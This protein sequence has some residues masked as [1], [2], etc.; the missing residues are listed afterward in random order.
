MGSFGGPALARAGSG[1]CYGYF[2]QSQAA[3]AWIA[4]AAAKGWRAVI[5]FAP[6]A[7]KSSLDLWPAP[8]GD[9]EIMKRI[10]NLFDPS[11]LL[12]RGRFYRLI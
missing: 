12:N 11:N 2:E 7:K 6:E 10:K 8:G 9:L 1:V 4:E 3:A 5:E